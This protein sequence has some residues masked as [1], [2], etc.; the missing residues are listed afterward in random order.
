[1]DVSYGKCWTIYLFQSFFFLNSNKL[2]KEVCILECWRI[3]TIQGHLNADTGTITQD[4]VSVE[5]VQNLDKLD[6][7]SFLNIITKVVIVRSSS[8]AI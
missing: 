6:V 3:E 4:M 5:F 2:N 1:M 8:V 7:K